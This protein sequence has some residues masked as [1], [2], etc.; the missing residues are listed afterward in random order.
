MKTQFLHLNKN[1]KELII[2]F[3]GFASKPCHYQHLSSKKNV[4]MVYDYK[5]LTLPKLD[6]KN[7]DKIS[8]IA[9][10]MGVCVATHFLSNLSFNKKIAINGTNFGIHKEK[11]IPPTLFLKTIKNLKIDD[12]KIFLFGKHLSKTNSFEFNSEIELKKELKSLYDYIL[13]TKEVNFSWDKI[14]ASKGDLIFPNTALLAS[15][16]ECIFVNEPHFLFFYF[17]SWD[18]F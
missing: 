5:D 4:L 6:I 18:E 13:N 1:S 17:D 12:F 2:F 9:F 15:F 10:S 3:A 8:L 11:G 7:Y 16:Q 14:Y